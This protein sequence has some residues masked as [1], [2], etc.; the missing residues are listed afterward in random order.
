MSKDYEPY[1]FW[2]NFENPNKVITKK[3]KEAVMNMIERQ[4]LYLKENIKNDI[5]ILDYG[6]G[7]GRTFKCYNTK[8]HEVVGA[9]ISLLYKDKVSEKAKKLGINFDWV[10]V[11]NNKIPFDD[12]DFDAAI[13]SQVLMHT[14]PIDILDVMNELKRVSKKVVVIT[15]FGNRDNKHIGDTNYKPKYT[16][17]PSFYYNFEKL[18]ND[19]GFNIFNKKIVNKSIMFCYN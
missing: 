8:Y 16:R 19:Y 13:C 17:T 7:V 9:D 5:R 11:P 12:N 10:H 4:V 18:C 6:C 15:Q 2:N 3:N 1:K 14:R